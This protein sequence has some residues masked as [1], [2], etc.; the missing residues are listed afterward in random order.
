MRY[1]FDTEFID[2]GESLLLISI[3]VVGENGREFYGI[4]RAA[5]KDRASKWVQDN[6]FTRLW[7]NIDMNFQPESA[8]EIRDRLLRFVGN[9]SEPEFWAYYGAHDWVVLCNLMGGMMNMPRGWPMLYREL[10]TELN[11][12]GLADL[13]DDGRADEHNALA[14]AVWVKLAYSKIGTRP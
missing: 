7:S 14:D 11:R 1:F 5:P 13:R 8:I 9:D 3:G 6:V 2:L 4:D 12:A 10:R